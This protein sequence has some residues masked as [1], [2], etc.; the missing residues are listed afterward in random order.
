MS[1]TTNVVVGLRKSLWDDRAILSIQAED[2][3][4]KANGRY[5]SRYLNQD[6][7][8]IS[9]PE[10]QFVRV[11]FTYNF[12]NFRL[13]DNKREIEKQELERLDTE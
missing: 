3:L 12:G 13:E 1:P 2:L 6:N 11:G 5:T 9:V 10:T 8:Y 7:G 4:G